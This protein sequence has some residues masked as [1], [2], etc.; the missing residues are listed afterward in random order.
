MVAM[1][2]N[3][4]LSFTLAALI[5]AYLIAIVFQYPV[6]PSALSL[7]HT[8]TDAATPHPTIITFDNGFLS[9]KEDPLLTFVASFFTESLHTLFYIK[10]ALFTLGLGLMLRTL[11]GLMVVAPLVSLAITSFAGEAPVLISQLLW[12]PWLAWALTTPQLKRLTSV[13]L[14]LFFSIRNVQ[15][16]GEIAFLTATFTWLL[17][18]PSIRHK[19][20]LTTLFV[21]APA[22]LAATT[23]TGV[24]LPTYPSEG[25]LVPDDTLPEP[26]LPFFSTSL[27]MPSLN[28]ALIKETLHGFSLGI[29]LLSA[30]LALFYRNRAMKVATIIAALLLFDIVPSEGTAQLFPLA[31]F[32]RLYPTLYTYAVIPLLI[33][34]FLIA[35]SLT[36]C[37]ILM[38]GIVS[39]TLFYH[40]F[41]HE[42]PLYSLGS[43]KLSAFN[44]AWEIPPFRKTVVS[45]SFYALFHHNF[46]MPLA[47][48]RDY[49]KL[50][51]WNIPNELRASR[52]EQ[53]LKFVAD[54]DGS[55][56]WSPQIGI[57]DGKNWLLLKFSKEI[58]T[59]L[60]MQIDS[61]VFFSDFARGLRISSSERCQSKD[62]G[63]FTSLIE[64]PRWE[65]SLSTTRRAGLPYFEYRY[66]SK[67]YFTQATTAQCYLIE[68]IGNNT[69]YD[70]SV[71][72]LIPLEQVKKSLDK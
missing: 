52:E 18:H 60:G 45:P 68:S 40:A 1:R 49:N 4:F 57:Q 25:R 64:Y 71:A 38:T 21:F 3:S 28:R 43:K 70:W 19:N 36:R 35:S 23:S 16:G 34:F 6:I 65:G 56:R 12:V 22:I 37:S 66:L 55:T 58:P 54:D 42:Q 27:P 51:L 17:V 47:E 8:L 53:D 5:S 9:F 63:N 69:E 24:P 72:S 13:L 44:H 2:T 61:G 59:L 14:V 32:C 10:L 20:F 41:R 33:G 15:A 11:G 31:N 46:K 50:R 48:G 67:I 39:L 7:I 30:I 29:T 62:D 26:L